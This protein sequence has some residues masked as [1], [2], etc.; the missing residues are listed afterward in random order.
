MLLNQTP[1][2]GNERDTRKSQRNV[3]HTFLC[4]PG[5]ADRWV[6]LRRRVG[7]AP[8]DHRHRAD[9]GGG[10][11]LQKSRRRAHR[12]EWQGS[13]FVAVCTAALWGRRRRRNRTLVIIRSTPS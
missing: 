5:T 3:A 10:L 6:Q 11:S 7:S 8:N 12:G 9:G 4:I 1:L 13:V 2:H